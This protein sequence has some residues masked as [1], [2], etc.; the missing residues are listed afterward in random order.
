MSATVLGKRSRAATF[1]EPTHTLEEHSA[2][3]HGHHDEHSDGPSN[4]SDE[5]ACD[6][7]DGAADAADL[8]G[9]DTERTNFEASVGPLIDL[10]SP[11][12]QDILA[13][14]ETVAAT[15]YTVSSA[16]HN[17]INIPPGLAWDKW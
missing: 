9:S 6:W 3:S 7:L 13:E 1:P 2:Q 15:K 12:L 17:G 14:T 10:S 11:Y 8:Y 4:E 16:P 5:D